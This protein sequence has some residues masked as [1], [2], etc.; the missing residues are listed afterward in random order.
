MAD[1]AEIL[2]K[3]GLKERE[4][5]VYEA[6]LRLGST[7]VVAIA[8]ETGYDRPAIYRIL[9]SLVAKGLIEKRLEGWKQ[10]YAASSPDQFDV[11]IAEQKRQFESVLPDMLALFK[12][13]GA[14][15]Q[16]KYY[17]GFEGLK[18]AFERNLRELKTGDVY[19]VYD[20]M[21]RWRGQLDLEW[22]NKFVERRGRKKNDA[23]LIFEESPTARLYKSKESAYSQKVKI[24]NTQIPACC[25]ITPFQV[26]ISNLSSSPI[27]TL[28]VEN[29]DMINFH[30][31]AFRMLWDL[32]PE[33]P[34]K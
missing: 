13:K 16:I 11:I 6:V 26:T 19:Y 8:R 4:A 25:V 12:L 30:I 20:N 24:V 18:A 17:E 9:T 1:I 34:A 10:K 28:V 5:V 7:G 23:R 3:L 21:D 29:E 14:R 27:V 22:L 2:T 33:E 31:A 32:L 15:S